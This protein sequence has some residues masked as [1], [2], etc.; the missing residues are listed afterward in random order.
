MRPPSE[1]CSPPSGVSRSDSVSATGPPAAASRREL[2]VRGPP[3]S[4]DLRDSAPWL[5]GLTP[6]VPRPHRPQAFQRPLPRAALLPERFRGPV[7]PSAETVPVRD[8]P[9]LPRGISGW[10]DL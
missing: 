2:L 6:S 8:H 3:L 10:V 7:A 5:Q 4:G 9:S 1:R